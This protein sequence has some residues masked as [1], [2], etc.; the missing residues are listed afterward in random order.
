MKKVEEMAEDIVAMLEEY[1]DPSLRYEILEELIEVTRREEELN[2]NEFIKLRR[3]VQ[4]A[5]VC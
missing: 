2:H 4:E 1:P 3:A 5:W